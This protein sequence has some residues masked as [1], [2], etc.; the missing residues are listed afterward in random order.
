MTAPAIRNHN[1]TV[2]GCAKPRVQNGQCAGHNSRDWRR[3][4][5]GYTSWARMLDRCSNPRNCDYAAYGGRGITVC[6]RWRESFQN[7]FE[8]MGPR[9]EGRSIDRID[10]DGNYEPGN[11]RW[12]TPHEQAI[13]Q[14]P[15][16]R[17]DRWSVN[18]DACRECHKSERRHE[19]KDLCTA[20]YQRAARRHRKAVKA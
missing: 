3:S 4:H 15:R 19:A 18:A 5:P 7:F 12:A 16:R 17:R 1:C 14:R 9:P 2:E 6:D 13:N 11:C 8:D 10:V 20:C